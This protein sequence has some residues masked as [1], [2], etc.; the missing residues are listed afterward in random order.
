MMQRLNYPLPPS[1]S[2]QLTIELEAHLG[3]LLA[4][5]ELTLMQEREREAFLA[6]AVHDLR[7]S[8]TG[9]KL[10]LYLLENG[11]PDLHEKYLG[12]L[13]ASVHEMAERLEQMWAH[14]HRPSAEHHDA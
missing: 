2:S 4:E 12:D 6:Q 8:I 13:K 7:G 11:K 14:L 3:S 9:M 1:N 10:E 5:H